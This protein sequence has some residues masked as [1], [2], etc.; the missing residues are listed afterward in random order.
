M[1]THRYQF[2]RFS[3]NRKLGGMA[4]TSTSRSTC[5]TRCSFKDGGG[6]YAENFPM[7]M[8]W[9]Q[10]DKGKRGSDLE[11]FCLNIRALPRG[12][13]WR[14][15]QQ[16]DLPGNG[17][18]IDAEALHQI[19]AANKGRLGFSYS[20][21]DPR[22]PGNAL[23]IKYANQ[24]GFTISLSAETLAEADEF[25]A[26]GV[27]PVVVI[28]PADQTETFKT[29]GGNTVIVCLAVTADMTCA[30]CGICAVADR[31]SIIGFPSHGGRK[32]KVEKIFWSKKEE[33]QE[34]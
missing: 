26:L 2:T 4:A 21:Y 34:A 3:A 7:S 9:D 17:V 19:V 23:A 5:P 18:D 33:L 13:L 6:C 27:A 8:N 12:S 29:V 31:K 10:L 28:L 11:Q 15:G 1:P 22:T 14:Y 24:H 32:K 25:V 16:G 20:H 30:T